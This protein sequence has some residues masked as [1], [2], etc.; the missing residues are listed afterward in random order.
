MGVL[1]VQLPGGKDL[2]GTLAHTVAATEAW[3]ATSQINMPLMGLVVQ[4]GVGKI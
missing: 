2:G 3:V 1:L 4:I